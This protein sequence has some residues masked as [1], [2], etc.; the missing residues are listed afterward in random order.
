MAEQASP[1]IDERTF[2]EVHPDRETS[3]RCNKCNRLMCADCAVQT[4]VGYRCKQCVRQHDDKF[5]TATPNDVLIVFAV[6]AGLAGVVGAIASGI[7][8]PLLFALILGFP[9]GGAIGTAA[10]RATKRRRARRSAEIGAAGVVVGG[11]VGA[12]VQAALQYNSVIAEIVRRSGARADQLPPL[13]LDYLFNAALGNIGL[14][15]LLGMMAAAVY[16][17]YRMRV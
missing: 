6:C 12:M 14:L 5:F 13:S 2:C 16:G 10:L 3:L 15:L 8:V 11:L 9:I 17:R 1:V 7:G 4:P